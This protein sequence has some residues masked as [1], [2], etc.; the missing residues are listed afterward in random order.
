[1]KKPKSI[2][3]L[4]E[5]FLSAVY[6]DDTIAEIAR[7]TD[8][9]GRTHT[10]DE[11]LSNP[12]NYEDVEI[13]FSTWGAPELDEKLLSALPSLKA[14]FYGAGSVRYFIT[15]AFWKRDIRLT[16]AYTG[17]AV[18]VAEYT[19]ASIVFSLKRA[20]AK[21]ADLKRGVFER[22]DVPGV[23]T[24]S[25]VGII[26]LGAIGRLVCQRLSAFSLDVIAYDPFANESVFEELSVKR[27]PSLEAL[28]AECDVVSLHA[29]WL[30]ETEGMITRKLLELLPNGAT[31]INTSRGAIVDEKALIEVLKARPDLFAVIDVITD[32]KAYTASPLLNLPN[33][34]LTPHIAGSGGRE[35][36]RL[37]DM[38]LDEC[39]RYLAGEPAM[40][41]VTAENIVRMA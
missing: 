7:L 10:P 18:P 26:S 1:M 37:G 6:S 15:D 19:V 31:F 11:V 12:A 8:N 22:M 17:N 36:H 14:F 24:G 35:C 21:N 20:W 13:V 40:I 16:S 41:P 32:E 9:D 4:T 30:R 25:R 5:D 34:F 3:L 28:F 29:P 23:Y 2:F 33:A 39:R 38:A 27:A